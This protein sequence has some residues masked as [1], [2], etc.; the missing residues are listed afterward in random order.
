MRKVCSACHLLDGQLAPAVF[1]S[2]ITKEPS[3]RISIS[4]YQFPKPDGGV[5]SVRR[6]A[7]LGELAEVLETSQQQGRDASMAACH[8]TP[9]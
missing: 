9:T 8:M 4:P 2:I 5:F 6:V 1:Q 7:R 3:R